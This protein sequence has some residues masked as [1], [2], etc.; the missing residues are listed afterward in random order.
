MALIK[1]DA[2][3]DD[4]WCLVA[5]GD[6]LPVD[7]AVIVTLDRWRAERDE[8]LKR[9]APLGIKL[10][11]G[12][13]PKEIADD[14]DRFDVI[15]L[16]FP[17]FKNG[18]GYSYARLLRERYGFD[19]EIRAVGD[20]LRDQLQFMARC[21]IDAFEV[22]DRVTLDGYREAMSEISVFFQPTGDGRTPVLSLRERLAAGAEPAAQTA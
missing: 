9:N 20:V 8:L 5:D 12:Q 6:E 14:L 11:S 2:F 7:C 18:R 13:E 16:E 3:A 4:P 17:Q 15:A 21:G 10:E 19:R 1:N 22:S